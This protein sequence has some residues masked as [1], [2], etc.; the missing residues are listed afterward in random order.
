MPP[1]NCDKR[2]TG[3][4]TRFCGGSFHLNI[5]QNIRE[6]INSIETLIHI[7]GSISTKEFFNNDIASK[8]GVI[9]SNFKN[10]SE[11]DIKT[12]LESN[13]LVTDAFV[14]IDTVI[15]DQHSQNARIEFVAIC[16]VRLHK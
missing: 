2:C 9:Y 5:Y 7:T 4:G 6:K 3:N 14:S 15:Q 12:L 11:R 16:K 10:E 8:N 13:L 1:S